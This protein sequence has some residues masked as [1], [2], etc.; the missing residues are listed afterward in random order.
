MRWERCASNS[1]SPI[2][3]EIKTFHVIW[4][5]E[6][7]VFVVSWLWIIGLLPQVASVTLDE[8]PEEEV[9]VMEAIGGNAS[10][11]AVYEACI[12]SGTRKLNANSSFEAR[13]DYIR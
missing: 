2:L 4:M 11:N 10:A 3:P 8:W 9:E 1:E 6:G 12:P 7:R 13:S 5:Y